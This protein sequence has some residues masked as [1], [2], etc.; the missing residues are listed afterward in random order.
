M[1]RPAGRPEQSGRPA[2]LSR[3]ELAH[4]AWRYRWRVDPAE[5]RWMLGVLKAGDVT[6]DAGA[7][8]GGYTYWMRRAVGER[9][10]VFAF[11][12]QPAAA[13]ML[14]RYVAAFRWTNVT[15][16]ES[17][18]SSS[19]GTCTL[20][21]PV[22]QGVSPAASLVGASLQPGAR[23]L[24][25]AIDPLDTWLARHAPGARVGLLK[26]DVEGHELDVLVGAR[27]TLA[28]HRPLLLV[29]CEARHLR[30][31]RMGEVFGWLGDHGYR[32]AFFER[33]ALEDIARFDAGV[34]QVTGRRPYVNNFVFVST[35]LA[36]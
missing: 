14:R 18:L 24:T 15:V 29:E 20:L 17:A 19:L 5:I 30:D 22:D 26:I 9:G 4:R 7:Y 34:H 6:V 28:E 35:E 25:V 21:T 8:K 16:S 2:W 3:V 23:A 36:E 27:R 13:A 12:P 31:A 1:N 10:A 11:E 32:G 33:G